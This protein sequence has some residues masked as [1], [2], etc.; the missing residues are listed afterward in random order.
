MRC[1]APVARSLGMRAAR[2]GWAFQTNDTLRALAE[3]GFAVD[4]SAI[5]RPVYPWDRGAKDWSTTPTRAYRPSIADYRI[6]GSPALPILE[7]PMS[8]AVVRAPYDS[9]E[10]V[11]YLNPAYRPE[12]LAPV[13]RGWFDTHDDAVLVTH[14]HE[15]YDRVTTHGLMASSAEAFEENVMALEAG[16]HASGVAPGSSRCRRPVEAATE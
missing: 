11:R 4:S 12:A 5:P 10:V 14:P 16:A 7:L 15:L 9:G 13:L 1:Y 6:P 8:V 2:M 3:A